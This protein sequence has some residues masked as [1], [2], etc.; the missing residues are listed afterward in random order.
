MK[1][2][3]II[4][5]A[6]LLFTS[7][8]PNKAIALAPPDR[9]DHDCYVHSNFDDGFMPDT[10]YLKSVGSSPSR[11]GSACVPLI[12]ESRDEYDLVFP[13]GPTV[14]DM[15]DD[16]FDSH[17]VVIIYATAPYFGNDYEIA[18][19]YCFG[20]GTLYIDLICSMPSEPID[21]GCDEH[22]VI[23][24]HVTND[25]P[26][27]SVRLSTRVFTGELI[28]RQATVIDV[29]A[30]EIVVPKDEL[31]G[32]NATPTKINDKATLDALAASH[33]SEKLNEYAESLGDDFFDSKFLL[34][35][36]AVSPNQAVAY[37][38]GAV[39][40]D[41]RNNLYINATYDRSQALDT[42]M[43]YTLILIALDRP[44]QDYAEIK[45]NMTERNAKGDIDGNGYIDVYDYVYA[46]RIYFGTYKP[47]AHEKYLAD[48][49]RDGAIDQYD[50]ILIKRIY[51]GTYTAD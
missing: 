47:N 3:A 51:F 5:L 30:L 42:A 28:S 17:Y 50:Y 9:L 15:N 49:N 32:K 46:R 4:F 18:D 8:T 31:Y 6:V 33:Q 38:V 41:D 22:S 35:F 16:Y 19:L 29:G 26:H 11:Y 21:G 10:E 45:L 12:V 1:R 20:A 36:L 40:V 27:E 24:I 14:I 34:R 48:V 37:E 23:E 25:Y 13:H 43:Q 2:L 39:S 44:S 7:L